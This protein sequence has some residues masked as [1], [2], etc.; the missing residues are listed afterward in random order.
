MSEKSKEQKKI[1]PDEEEDCHWTPI[2]NAMD[3]FLLF[4]TKTPEIK[5]SRKK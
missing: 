4:K 3:K 1:I 5:S 2:I